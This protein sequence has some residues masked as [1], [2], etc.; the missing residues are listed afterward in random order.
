MNMNASSTA[1]KPTRTHV[2]L[3]QAINNLDAL[4]AM[5]VI[6]QKLLA[7][8]MGTEES[9]KKL[10]AL[11]EQDPQISA[12]IIGL[13][14]SSMISTTR[15]VSTTRDATM[16][17]GIVRVYSVSIGIAIMSLMNKANHKW[18]NM[19]D[20]W[21]HSL[22]IAFAMTGIARFMPA[23]SRPNDEQILLAGLLHDIGFLALAFLDPQRSDKLHERLAE[24]PG[25]PALDIEKEMLELS[26]DEL[27]AE[28]AR[29]WD[30][31]DEIIAVLRYHHTPDEAAP[32]EWQPLARMVNIAEKLL[33]S[34]G[35]NE[36]VDPGVSDNEWKALGIDPSR[37]E[38]IKMAVAKQADHAM[39]LTSTFT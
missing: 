3:R 5:P 27:G 18:F 2:D 14:N 23:Q 19:Q 16:L 12:K 35:L 25:R 28:L 13:A 21:L 7:L 10:L 15:K 26:H 32:A 29:H 11:I 36:Y 38:E 9:E 31:P 34:F 6:A 37:A 24:E 17:L 39:Q 1:A 30:L 22:G 33:T 8:Q 20:L 4:P